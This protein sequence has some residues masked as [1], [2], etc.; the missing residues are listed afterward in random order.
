MAKRD[1]FVAVGIGCLGMAFFL[2]LNMVGVF[3][4]IS[5]LVVFSFIG[6]AVSCYG[7]LYFDKKRNK[8]LV[9]ERE[10]NDLLLNAV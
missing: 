3:N 6:L 4:E 1:D 8:A 2:V 10:K 5:G 9:I 7:C